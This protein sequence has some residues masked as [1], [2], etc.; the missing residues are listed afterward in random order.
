MAEPTLATSSRSDS[1]PA[2]F[3]EHISAAVRIRRGGVTSPRGPSKQSDDSQS[4]EKRK[5]SFAG[6]PVDFSRF[7]PESEEALPYT[8]LLHYP[9]RRSE[10]AP[11]AFKE[12]LPSE[13]E[14][15]LGRFLFSSKEALPYTELFDY[16]KPPPEKAPESAENKKDSDPKVDL[17]KFMPHSKE[18]LAYT[19]ITAVP[20]TS[21]GESSQSWL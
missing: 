2:S 19:G 6:H 11:K 14:V 5:M 13:P 12:R 15:D 16:P 1:W 9:K 4:T 8:E 20:R 18:A 17:E 3:I 7:L 10:E 21:S